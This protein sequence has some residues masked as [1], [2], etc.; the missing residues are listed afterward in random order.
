[1]AGISDQALSFGKINK[2]RFQGQEQQS[3]EFAD[4][5]GLEMYEFKYRFDDPQIGRF[6]SVDPLA[7]KY[8]YNSTYAFSEDKVISYVEL[9]GLEAK[10]AISGNGH[11]NTDY[12][13]H[14]A[15]RGVFKSRAERLK[16]NG[17]AV[18]VVQNGK[19]L[20]ST[21]KD[22]T[23]K[24][25]SVGPV[26]IFSHSSGVGLY[27]DNN[28]G[29]YTGSSTYSVTDQSATVKDLKASVNSGDIKFDK[30][31]VI[32][33]AGCNTEN[34]AT[35]QAGQEPLAISI[36][37]GLGITTY[38]ATGSVDAEKDANGNETGRLVTDDGSFF[39]NTLT[40]N[41]MTITNIQGQSVQIATGTTFTQTNLG[42]VIDP[43]ALLTQQPPTTRP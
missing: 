20:I 41:Y 35:V 3:K 27:L 29:F 12:A 32:L 37:K 38:G 14:P 9:E 34:P 1:M 31:A 19:E 26:A 36:T 39:K 6:W 2:Y 33:F 15:D 24:E 23:A 4:G 43:K 7:D 16:S 25:G 22:A 5:S 10:L 13:K 40:T 17:F 21:L 30:S 8:V 18:K 42:N 28:S 11:E